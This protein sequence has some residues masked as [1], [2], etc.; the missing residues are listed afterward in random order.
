MRAPEEVSSV[1]ESAGVGERGDEGVV[2]DGARETPGRSSIGALYGGFGGPCD[3]VRRAEA[4]VY[5][6][7][8]GRP[9]AS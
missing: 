2:V 7:A 4:R 9:P 6:Q 1:E 8:F 5:G 3:V